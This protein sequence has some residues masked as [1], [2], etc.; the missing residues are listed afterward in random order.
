MSELPIVSGKSVI[1]ALEKAGFQ[2]MRQ[3]GSHCQ[4]RHPD[5]RRATVPIHANRDM[6]RGTLKGI[7]K[8]VEITVEHF[9]ELL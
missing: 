8:D 5:G 3:T 6:P 7:L 9:K 1:R 2:I 4:I